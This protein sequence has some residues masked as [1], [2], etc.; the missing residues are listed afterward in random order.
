MAHLDSSAD[1][2]AWKILQSRVEK[3][4]KKKSTS[5]LRLIFGDATVILGGEKMRNNDEKKNE[6]KP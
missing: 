1:A 2:A 6:K 3:Q 5:Q 4:E